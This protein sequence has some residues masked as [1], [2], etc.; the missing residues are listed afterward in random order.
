VSKLVLG[1]STLLFREGT[2]VGS[3]SKSS[4][5]L[6]SLVSYSQCECDEIKQA[7]SKDILD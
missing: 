7:E 2:F 5:H 1:M 4:A 3:L 6:S